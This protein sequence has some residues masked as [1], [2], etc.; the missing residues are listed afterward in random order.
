MCGYSFY[1]SPYQKESILDPCLAILDEIE[2]RDNEQEYPLVKLDDKVLL[3]YVQ[4]P[5]VWFRDEGIS[6]FVQDLF[7]V[8]FSVRDS[9]ITIPIRD[10]LG[11]LVGVKGRTILEDISNTHSRYWFPYPVPKTRILYGLDKSYSYIMKAG[12]VLVFESEKSV[13]KAFSMGFC[14]CVSIGGHE[15]SDTQVLK[16]EKLGVDIILALDYDVSTKE[17]KKQADKFLMRDRVYAIIPHKH[18]KLLEDKDA[19]VDRGIDVFVKLYTDDLY[20][21]PA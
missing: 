17:V 7:Q 10:E 15:V 8:G 21:V 18:K 6:H 12:R 11:N 4:Y 14:N 3:E 13:Q 5:N 16:L 2:P 1:D 19:P 9:C 20:K